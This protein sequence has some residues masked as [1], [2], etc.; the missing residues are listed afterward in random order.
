M[1]GT[2]SGNFIIGIGCFLVAFL[3]FMIAQLDFA[4]GGKVNKIAGIV[5]LIAAICIAGMGIA[6]FVQAFLILW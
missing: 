3:D 6:L 5:L 1:F 4:K 2:I